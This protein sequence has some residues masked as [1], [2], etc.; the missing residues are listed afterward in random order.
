MSIQTGIKAG[1]FLTGTIKKYNGNGKVTIILNTAS[2]ASQYQ[3]EIEA[4]IPSSWIGTEG[5]FAGGYPKVGSTVRVVQGHNGK[6]A[7][8]G[9]EADAFTFSNKTTEILSGLSLNNLRDLKPDRYLIRTK[10]NNRLYLDPKGFSVGN[11]VYSL[12]LNDNTIKSNFKQEIT[13]T[14]SNRIISGEIKRDIQ[15]NSSRNL[16]NSTLTS[17]DYDSSLTTIGMDPSAIVSHRN[18]KLTARNPALAESRE[19]V[20]EFAHDYKFGSYDEE[21]SNYISTLNNHEIV[22]SSKSDNRT[23]PLALTLEQPNNLIETI[24]GT[25]V[26]SFG[27]ILDI[28]RN[29]LPIGKLDKISLKRNQDKDFAYKEIIRELRKSITYHF[30]INSRKHIDG[31]LNVPI[32]EDTSDY[33]R[34]RS[35]FSIDI[36]KEGQFK[37]N[38][39]ASS[40]TGNIPL[41]T[42]YE[43]YSV[44]AS[45]QNS[46]IHP[47][48]FNKPPDLKDIYLENFAGYTNIGLSDTDNQF[49]GYQ[50]PIDRITEKPIKLGTAYHD[51]TNTC[52]QFL[53]SAPYIEAGKKL[54]FFDENNLLNKQ[55]IPLEKIVSDNI[56][57]TGDNANAGGRSGTINLDGFLSLNIGANTIDRQSLWIDTAGSIIQNIGRDKNNISHAASFDGYVFWQIGGPGIPNTYDS[58]FEDQDDAYRNGA[59]DIRVMINGQLAI[60][61]IGEE[62]ISIISPG[63]INIA[64]QQDIILK[65]NSNIKFEAPNIVMY[66]ETSKRIVSKNPANTQ[67]V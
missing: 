41:L 19:V 43:N 20:Y 46:E 45:K 21:F 50:S 6:W 5:E 38:V 63:R 56:I 51:I 34:D 15:P 48:S 31:E 42:R 62:G 36:D 2:I 26:D 58:R 11:S 39:P 32:P 12:D 7:C 28:N 44:L 4:S 29:I 22:P 25:V 9:Y 8:L 3:S 55:W 10:K 24:K 54:V 53:S 49:D 17:I 60:F 64:S 47:D 18:S 1:L 59:L 27:N 37:I 23:V 57:I 52:Y 65:S 33:A 40:E 13:F 30:E 66:A 67:I 14:E 61:R 16:I 35:K